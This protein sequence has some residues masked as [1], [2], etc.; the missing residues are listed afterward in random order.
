MTEKNTVIGNVTEED[1]NSFFD[2]GV[3]SESIISQQEPITPSSDEK[4][5]IDKNKL[6]N[7]T[8]AVD[9]DLDLDNLFANK[10]SEGGDEDSEVVDVLAS[11]QKSSEPVVKTN[12]VK[13]FSF[14]DDLIKSGDLF[15]FEDDAPIKTEDDLKA[16]IKGNIEKVREDAS[17]ESLQEFLEALPREVALAA[18]YAMQGGTD[19]KSFFKVLSKVEDT[20]DLDISDEDGQEYVVSV[21][22]KKQGFTDEEI[23]DEIFDLKES[24]KLANRAAAYKPKIEADV[25][26]EVEQKIAE[27]QEIESKRQAAE[28]AY[29]QNVF[30]AV[31][32]GNIGDLKLDKKLQS[33]LAQGLTNRAY[34]SISGSNTNLLGA[35]LEKVQFLE[36][37]YKLLLEATWLLADE[38]GYK[39]KVRD[40]VGSKIAATNVRKIKAANDADKAGAESVERNSKGGIPRIKNSGF[41]RELK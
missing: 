6:E 34:K 27:Q 5:D 32:D 12:E 22:L 10:D 33:Y 35:L 25:Q 18:Q 23:E 9:T 40:T 26:K 21:M 3:S 7:F 30:D 37:N 31:K 15:G 14:V 29:K 19:M 17:K 38:Q 41:F 16:L 13:S 11:T 20:K 4:K 1:I 8:A 2:V 39:E 28:S 36:P 24:G